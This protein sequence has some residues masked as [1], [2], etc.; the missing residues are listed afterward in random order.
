MANFSWFDYSNYAMSQGGSDTL[1]YNQQINTHRY[2]RNDIRE[3]E[4]LLNPEDPFTN[5]K[6]M[7]ATNIFI[8]SNG[9]ML[10]MVQS[11]PVNETRQINKLQ[12]IGWEGVVQAVPSNTRGGTLQLNRVA[13]Y[14]STL[15]GSL[16]LTAD[17]RPHNAIGHHIHQVTTSDLQSY[18]SGGSPFD[19]Y[20]DDTGGTNGDLK[21]STGMVFRTLKDQ[22]VPLEIMVKTRMS[23]TEDQFF[24]VTYIDC[25]LN[26]YS[27][28]Y[29]VQQIY[30][31]ETAG[32]AYGDVY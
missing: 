26:S 11:L 21:V 8:Y 2:T 13:L 14:D 3:A 22:R 32:I 17:G 29:G 24:T 15:Y 4:N 6:V 5:S 27:K 16:G 10:G 7:L 1:D 12:A 28:P 25:W 9:G 20:N 30:V 19:T 23:G 18:T 31:A